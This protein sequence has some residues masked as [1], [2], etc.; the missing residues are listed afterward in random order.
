[1][2]NSNHVTVL[3]LIVGVFSLRIAINTTEMLSEWRMDAVHNIW[4]GGFYLTFQNKIVPRLMS[5][6]HT[7]VLDQLMHNIP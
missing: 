2:L 3:H 1:M 4:N 6:K 5:N 7:F